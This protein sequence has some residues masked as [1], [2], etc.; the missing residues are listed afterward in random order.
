MLVALIYWAKIRN[1]NKIKGAL[2][3]YGNG[4]SLQF[5]GEKTKYILKPHEQNA[6]QYYKNVGNKS[7][8]AR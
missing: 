1:I 6:G 2:L 7:L 4:I 5:N 8:K 3:V